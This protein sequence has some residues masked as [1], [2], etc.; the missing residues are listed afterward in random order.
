MDLSDSDEEKNRGA[1]DQ[2]TGSGDALEA[3]LGRAP[4]KPSDDNDGDILDLDDLLADT[5]PTKKKPPAPSPTK[6]A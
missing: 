1:E 3:M 2:A 5:D 6:L 4:K